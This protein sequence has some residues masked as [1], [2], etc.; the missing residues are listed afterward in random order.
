MNIVFVTN[1]LATS[2]NPAQG[3]A[4]FSANIARIFAEH[5]HRVSIVLVSTKELHIEFQK[6]IDIISLHVPMEKW[7]KMDKISKA[8]GLICKDGKD[9][10]RRVIIC[11]YKAWQTRKAIL[12]INRKNNIDIVLYCN[13]RALDRLSPKRIPYVL[14]IAQFG[15]ILKG[16]NTP[17]GSIKYKDIPLSLTDKLEEYTIKKAKYVVAPSHLLAGMAKENIGLDVTVIESPF[18]LKANEW[19]YSVLHRMGLEEK[20]YIIH[21]AGSLRYLKGTHIVAMLAKKFLQQYPDY[22][23]VMSGD[24]QEITDE[25][26]HKMKA[27]EF[28]KKSAEEFAD[29]VIYA[30]RLVREQLYPLIQNAELCLFPS[31]IENLSNAC[32]EAMAMGKIVVATNGASYEQLIDDGVSGFLCE[33]D[34]PDS[35]LKAIN[36]A[37]NMSVE[38]KEKMGSKALEVTKRLEPQKIYKEY[39]KFFEKVIQEW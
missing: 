13:S 12:D 6:D 27:D 2:N 23:I 25:N 7:I 9:V 22:Y 31:R 16:A 4:S 37:L 39:L 18:M 30:G 28:V 11:L 26:G 14:R 33:R 17:N 38:D 29:R 3:A 15:S 36:E 1:Q 20:K 24:S 32:I 21:Y 5:G 19:D 35:Y 10:V 8:L 34:N